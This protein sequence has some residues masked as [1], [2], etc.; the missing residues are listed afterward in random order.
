MYINKCINPSKFNLPGFAESFTN[1]FTANLKS[2]F[3][4]NRQ[5][6]EPMQAL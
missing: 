4:D 2:T 3:V 6:N 1:L 5:I